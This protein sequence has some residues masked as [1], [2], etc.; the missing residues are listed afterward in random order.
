MVQ[1]VCMDADQKNHTALKKVF[2]KGLIYPG[3]WSE[4]ERSTYSPPSGADADVPCDK[5]GNTSLVRR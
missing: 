3:I 5:Y 4:E 2:A 1:I